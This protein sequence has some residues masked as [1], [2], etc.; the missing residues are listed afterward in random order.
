MYRFI[1]AILASICLTI[2]QIDTAAAFKRTTVGAPSH[3]FALNSL[4][5][6]PLSLF[7]ALGQ[8]AT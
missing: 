3:D 6:A 1:F 2:G 4:E 7:D 8:R 5:G